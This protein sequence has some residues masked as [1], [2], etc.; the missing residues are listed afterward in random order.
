MLLKRLVQAEADAQAAKRGMI[1]L[2]SAVGKIQSVSTSIPVELNCRPFS[3]LLY[4]YKALNLR[5]VLSMMF[6]VQPLLTYYIIYP[7]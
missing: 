6:S 5:F 3:N 7:I 4:S 2:R 1:D